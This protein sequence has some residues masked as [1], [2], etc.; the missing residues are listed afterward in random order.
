MYLEIEPRFQ[1]RR[2]G[3]GAT[4]ASQGA[5]HGVFDNLS[6]QEI[7]SKEAAIKAAE[8]AKNISVSSGSNV[9]SPSDT[10]TSKKPLSTTAKMLIVTAVI[11]GAYMIYKIKK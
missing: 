6:Q 1:R 2:S 11:V 4:L 8:E 10:S 5:L 7:A 9:S 3:S